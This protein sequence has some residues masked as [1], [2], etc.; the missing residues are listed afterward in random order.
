MITLQKLFKVLFISSKSSFRSQDIEIFVIFSL[1]FQTFQILKDKWKW[2][3]D[4]MSW[5]V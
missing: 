3:N 1:P 5:L 2:N 4:V